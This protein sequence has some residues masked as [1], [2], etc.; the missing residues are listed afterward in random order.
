M[1]CKEAPQRQRAAFILRRRQQKHEYKSPRGLS[2]FGDYGRRGELKL[3]S[4][5]GNRPE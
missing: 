5:M 3:M 2:Q 4:R 1:A